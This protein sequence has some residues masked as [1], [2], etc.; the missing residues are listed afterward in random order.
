MSETNA[1]QDYLADHPR[2]IGA[3]F[4]LCLLLSQAGAVAAGNGTTVGG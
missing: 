2:M 1:I 4:M 3:L